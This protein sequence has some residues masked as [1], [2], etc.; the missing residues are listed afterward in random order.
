[1]EQ[2]YKYLFGPVPSRRLGRS[3]GVDL[4]PFKT[5]SFDCVFCQ[6]GRTTNKT[7]ERREYVPTAEV[8]QELQHWIEHDG[9][10]DT[11]TLSGSG[12][13]TLHTDFDTIIADIQDS[14]TIPVAVLTNG[15]MLWDK[16]VRDGA[17]RANIVKV[18]LSAWNP[19][20]F[21]RVN[22]PHPDLTLERIVEGARRLREMFPGELWVEVFI[23][24]G[25]NSDQNDVSEI[26]ELVRSIEPDRVQLNT[27]VRPPAES[28][29]RAAPIEELAKLAELFTPPGEVAAEFSSELS[30]TVQANEETILEMLARRPCTAEQ[31]ATVFDM[32]GN[33]VSKY[34][35]KLS[36]TGQIQ[37]ERKGDYVYYIT[38][39]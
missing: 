19:L 32:H 13:P 18:S 39:K 21:K 17:A 24:W 28:F 38:T 36:R 31:I 23:V 34:L 4:T 6:L 15:S 35:G 10:A 11:I 37:P 30:S 26:A 33:E 5:C 9:Q 7:L 16:A 1:M 27:A 20:S 2:S 14:T 29:V 8:T 3:L 22:R 12:E 25:M